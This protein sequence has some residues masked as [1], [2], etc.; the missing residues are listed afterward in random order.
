MLRQ[1][2]E[3]VAGGNWRSHQEVW[4]DP[5][6]GRALTLHL[7]EAGE[8]QLFLIS[9]AAQHSWITAC[10]T[11]ANFDL[12]QT[13][14]FFGAEFK[15]VQFPSK[16]VYYLMLRGEQEG[17]IQVDFRY[18]YVNPIDKNLLAAGESLA[19]TLLQKAHSLKDQQMI[20]TVISDGW[21]RK[22]H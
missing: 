19:K 16:G 13:M 7:D 22:A 17:P 18:S 21:G 1:H 14:R 8:V 4:M 5:R 3:L 15:H 10:V 9:R 11:S 2:G 12:L 20:N 6:G